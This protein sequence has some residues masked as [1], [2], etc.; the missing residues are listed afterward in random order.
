MDDIIT[1][2]VI[3]FIKKAEIQIGIVINKQ[4]R[5]DCLK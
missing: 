5:T 3:D 4:G 2:C 1:L